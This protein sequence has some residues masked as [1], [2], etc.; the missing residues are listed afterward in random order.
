MQRNDCK[1]SEVINCEAYLAD[2]IEVWFL[3]LELAESWM[4]E[5]RRLWRMWDE[6]KNF[7]II[8]CQC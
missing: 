8:F 6:K 5:D 4:I 1:V 2:I 3:A 7:L